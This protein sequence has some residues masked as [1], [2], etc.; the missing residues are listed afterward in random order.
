MALRS[1]PFVAERLD[2]RVSQPTDGQS[3]IFQDEFISHPALEQT[4]GANESLARPH[5][6]T[7][8]AVNS[9]LRKQSRGESRIDVQRLAVCF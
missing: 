6:V 2:D 9:R 3:V 5:R 4:L 8:A 1:K 7:P